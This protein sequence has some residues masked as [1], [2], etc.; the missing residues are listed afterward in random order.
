MCNKNFFRTLNRAK[1][2]KCVFVISGI[3]LIFGLFFVTGMVPAE[4]AAQSLAASEELDQSVRDILQE[5]IKTIQ[6]ARNYS[7]ELK[8]Q[9]EIMGKV[10]NGE[11][12]FRQKKTNE[13][14]SS[15]WEMKFTLDHFIFQK[16]MYLSGKK[17]RLGVLTVLLTNNQEAPHESFREHK[18]VN[19]AS[20]KAAIEKSPLE[21]T[22]APPWYSQPNGGQ[23]LEGILQSYYFTLCGE[24][25]YPRT[26]GY[27]YRIQGQLKPEFT[28]EILESRELNPAGG[29]PAL[30]GEVPMYVELMIDKVEKIPL[31]IRFYSVRMSEK[32]SQAAEESFSYKIVFEQNHLGD[33]SWPDSDCE[34]SPDKETYDDTE[35]YLKEHRS[36]LSEE[37]PRS[38][39]PL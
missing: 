21:Y 33:G 28:K 9:A 13:I 11:G 1:Y 3:L 6:E 38:A 25:L 4:E 24:K 5:S 39:S 26:S 7:A 20:V 16:A 17:E 32:K 35:E 12:V 18:V 15:Y 22:I 37:D 10:I 34:I 31:E 19:L 14:V 23:I 29:L 36:D 2:A 8:C 27:C 30:P